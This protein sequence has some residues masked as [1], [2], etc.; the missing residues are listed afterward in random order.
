MFG[1]KTKKQI[2][3]QILKIEKGDILLVKLDRELCSSDE[4]VARI[5]KVVKRHL[6][7]VGKEDTPV[8]VTANID[9]SI[10]R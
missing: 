9:Y 3:T 7:D 1:I 2:K 5:M 6:A 8:L 10:L 4:D